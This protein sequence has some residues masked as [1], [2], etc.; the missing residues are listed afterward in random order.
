MFQEYYHH[1]PATSRIIPSSIPTVFQQFFFAVFC[2]QHSNQYSNI[3]PLHAQMGKIRTLKQHCAIKGTGFRPTPPF[4]AYVHAIS[5]N[6][7]GHHTPKNWLVLP[8]Q[9]LCLKRVPL[10]TNQHSQRMRRLT[11][12]RQSST[13][14]YTC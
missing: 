11:R 3:I 6:R 8:S 4:C 12:R 10:V 5:L 14:H 9:R 2:H 1:C 7:S 13:M